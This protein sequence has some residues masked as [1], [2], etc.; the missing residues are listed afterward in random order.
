MI[1][2]H[3]VRVGSA[4]GNH[5]AH[6]VKHS[7]APGKGHG[8]AKSYQRIH[9][10][11]AVKQGGKTACEEFAVDD[12]D[13]C[14]QQKLGQRQGKMVS[15]QK[16]GERRAEHMHAHGE[17]HQHRQKSQGENQAAFQF[18]R[19]S[20]LQRIFRIDGIPGRTF[21]PGAVSGFFHG[22]DN[23]AVGGSA[24]DTHGIGQQADSAGSNPGDPR[25]GFFHPGL[26][27]SAAHAGNG[28]L[29]HENTSSG[30]RKGLQDINQFTP[31][32]AVVIQADSEG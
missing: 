32:P 5:R 30:F 10:R 15:F 26:A 28:I 16:S 11:C 4:A 18:R 7:Q 19:F 17:I 8:R 31:A 14:S 24:F 13:A 23:L 25:Y 12:H 9:I 21:H 2:V 22:A 1:Q 6:P 3:Q 20:V 29:F 27:G